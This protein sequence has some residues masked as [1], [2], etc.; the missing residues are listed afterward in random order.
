M[1]T[2][3]L[4]ILHLKRML[5]NKPV[6]IFTILLPMFA[7]CLVT[8]FT[9][10]ASNT[11]SN[12]LYVDFVNNDTGAASTKLISEFKAD[13]NINVYVASK[14]DAEYRVEH[15]VTGEAIIIPS[16][17]SQSLSKGIAPSLQV[18]KLNSGN[19][20]IT[21]DNKINYFINENLISKEISKNVSSKNT[22]ANL[23]KE[24]SK[25]MIASSV[26][27]VTKTKGFSLSNELS[28]NLSI[29]FMMFTVIFIVNEIIGRRDD[30]TLKRSFSTSNSKFTLLFSFVLAFL[31]VGWLQ[32][33]LV[34]G[35]TSLLFKLSWGSSSVALFALFTSLL[36]VVLG[37]GIL[38]CRIVK[39]ASNAPIVCQMVVQL[40]CIIG[41]SYMPLEYFPD[42]LKHVA[43]LMPQSWAVSALSD[44]VLKNKGL[45]YILP[46]IGVLL[47]FALAFFTAGASAIKSSFEN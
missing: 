34:V 20:T 31:V 44:I 39:S 47:L 11:T 14:A 6:I 13:E 35:S 28:I 12:S 37:L 29:S 10:N 40:S 36:L 1:Q 41:G 19:I 3:K 23:L 15:N 22:E 33:L 27:T 18:L 42:T 8:F 2:L 4:T 26:S 17:F 38:L 43:Y 24:I 30:N 9:G 7:I 45:Y 16:N 21:T 46:D 25:N 5:T 32:V